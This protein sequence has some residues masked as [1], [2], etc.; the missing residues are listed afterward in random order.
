MEGKEYP[1]E[2]LREKKKEEVPRWLSGG[3]Q[4]KAKRKKSSAWKERPAVPFVPSFGRKR[5]REG[6]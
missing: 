3:N 5:G 1:E 4:G 6:K 2:N